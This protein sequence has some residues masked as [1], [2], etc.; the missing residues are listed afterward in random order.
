[1]AK[2]LSL[3][4]ALNDVYLIEDFIARVFAGRGFVLSICAGIGSVD[5]CISETNEGN[6][7]EAGGAVCGWRSFRDYTLLFIRE[8]CAYLYY[9]S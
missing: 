2:I 4:S 7:L 1:M 3:G 6:D 9:G 5:D 8:Y